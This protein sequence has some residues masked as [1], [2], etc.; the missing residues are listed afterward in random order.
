MK[1]AYLVTSSVTTRV[2][3]DCS[4][5]EEKQIYDEALPRLLE[6]LRISVLELCTDIQEDL[7]VPYDKNYDKNYDK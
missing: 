7:E 4:I 6:N 5:E 2:V 3:I 1:K